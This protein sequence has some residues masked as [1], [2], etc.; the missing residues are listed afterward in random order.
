MHPCNGE[1]ENVLDKQQSQWLKFVNV[2][3]KLFL[4]P[5]E[6]SFK[7]LRFLLAFK[8]RMQNKTKQNK[9]KAYRICFVEFLIEA[10]IKNLK[11][12]QK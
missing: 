5:E 2:S 7:V 11:D 4:C 9:T 10:S 8:Y 6:F 1:K 12:C 3:P